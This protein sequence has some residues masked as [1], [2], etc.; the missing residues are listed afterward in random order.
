MTAIKY[1]LFCLISFALITSFLLAW[2]PLIIPLGFLFMSAI[3]YIVYARDKYAA[4]HDEGRIPENI[5]HVFSLLGG[6]PGAIIA[7]QT[8]RHK[9]R[10]PGFQLMFWLVMLINSAFLIW[11]HT[12]EGNSEL[13]V[14]ITALD[15]LIRSEFATNKFSN[16]LLYLLQYRAIV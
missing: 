1:I 8:L 4:I 11:L 12:N 14:F 3:T 2:T 7:Q 6:W 5:L 16:A 15:N 10:K 13:L 9:T